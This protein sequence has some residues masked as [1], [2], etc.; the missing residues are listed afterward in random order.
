[1]ELGCWLV[2]QQLFRYKTKNKHV[3][4]S[5]LKIVTECTTVNCIKLNKNLNSHEQLSQFSLESLH[6]QD[7]IFGYKNKN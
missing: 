3:G 4:D 5:T 2:I 7:D 6:S 1:V